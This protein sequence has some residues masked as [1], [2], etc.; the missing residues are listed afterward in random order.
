[1]KSSSCVSQVR[2]PLRSRTS[3]EHQHRTAQRVL[4]PMLTAFPMPT[5]SHMAPLTYDTHA[6]AHA[7]GLCRSCRMWNAHTHTRM[8][9]AVV[10]KALAPSPHSQGVVC[11]T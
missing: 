2:P 11:H 1:M 9:H 7:R 10:S 8:P 6:H 4:P 3:P 5:S